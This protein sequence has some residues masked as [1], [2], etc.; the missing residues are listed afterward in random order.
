M[1]LDPQSLA[2]AGRRQIEDAVLRLLDANP[3]GLR[4]V[5][6]A[7]ALGLS[8]EFS[9]KYKN[10]LTHGT[11]GSLESRGLVSRDEDSKLFFSR[12]GDAPGK[13]AA[14]AGLANIESAILNLL[15]DYPDGLRNVD[16]ANR[17]GLNSEFRGSYRN[18]L[19]YT[20]LMSL[21]SQGKVIRDSQTKLF[22]ITE[23]P[24]TDE[25]RNHKPTWR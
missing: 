19:T 21:Q 12:N 15:S 2:Q 18:Y 5:D 16:I 23:T 22:T 24:L 11:L 1:N 6:I 7:R 20:V 9:G 13:E 14:Q 4:N 8:F 17:L 3:Q 25:I 10:H